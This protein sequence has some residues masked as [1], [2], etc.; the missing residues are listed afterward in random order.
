MSAIKRDQAEEIRKA[1]REA[2]ER[3]AREQGLPLKV[4]DPATIERVASLLREAED[5]RDV[6]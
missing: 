2:A 6:A 5:E 3:T 4:T 1:A